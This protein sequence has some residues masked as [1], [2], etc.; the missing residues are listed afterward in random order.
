MNL[1]LASIALA[2]TTTLVP[3]NDLGHGSYLWGYYGGLWDVVNTGDETIPPDHA[4]AGLRRSALIQPR[5]EDGN[6]DPNGK[7]AFMSVGYGNTQLTFDKFTALASANP[8]VNHESLVMVNAAS[9]NSE[10]SQWEFPWSPVYTRIANSA[11][12]PAHVTP[13]QVQVV[14]LQQINQNPYTPLPIQYADSYLLK[15]TIANILRT[16]KTEFPNLQVAYLS[17]P[18]YGGYGT[19]KFLGEPY[20]YEDG[21]ADRWVILG[22][23]LFMKQGEIWDPRIANLDYDKGVAPWVTW[24]PYMWANGA[25][26]RADGTTWL[27]SDYAADGNTL[28]DAGATKSANLL[29][30]FLLNEPTAAKWFANGTALPAPP[31]PPAR[32][33]S[34][35]P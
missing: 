19:G 28:S 32:R 16:L 31:P 10:A 26:P 2:A 33:R 8:R 5:D 7:I 23:I 17:D 21:Y 30:T 20:A 34:V 3:M 11:L 25:T 15:A 29:M 22:Q 1:L 4:A 24:G 12:L 6:P 35:K 9:E 18:Q 14:W 13:A 27:R